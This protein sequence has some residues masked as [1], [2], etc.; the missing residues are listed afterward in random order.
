[1]QR[2]SEDQEDWCFNEKNSW[3][4]RRFCSTVFFVRRLLRHARHASFRARYGGVRGIQHVSGADWY[5]VPLFS[6]IN[7]TI[8][9]EEKFPDVPEPRVGQDL[10]LWDE[11]FK[12]VALDDDKG[13][14]ESFSVL[15]VQIFRF[16]HGSKIGSVSYQ[17]S[18][19]LH[20]QCC[21]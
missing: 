5:H 17:W 12:I 21:R 16:L 20:S 8:L 4:L 11:N 9:H 10:P 6:S 13:L 7:P 18:E 2:L 14:D 15:L 3:G 1:M 19:T